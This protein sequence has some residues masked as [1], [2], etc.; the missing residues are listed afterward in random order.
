[1]LGEAPSDAFDASALLEEPM[2][3]VDEVLREAARIHGL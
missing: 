3:E 1:M 2:Q